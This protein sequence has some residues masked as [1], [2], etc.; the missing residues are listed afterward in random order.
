MSAAFEKIWALARQCPAGRVVTYGQLARLAGNPRWAR[1]AGY[2]M[3]GCP[4]DVPW[5]RVVDRRGRLCPGLEERQRQLLEGEGV[6]FTQEGYV[7]LRRFSWL[8]M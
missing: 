1:V 3:H 8:G 2:A 5:H 4:G 7:E 6:A